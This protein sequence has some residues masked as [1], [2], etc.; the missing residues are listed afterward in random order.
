MRKGFY[1]LLFILIAGFLLYFFSSMILTEVS[2][3][4]ISYL[5]ANIKI[6]NFEYTRP[7]FKDVRISAFNTVTWYG[8][9]T[10][11][12]MVRNEIKNT[13]EC[14]SVRIKEFTIALES[15][16]ERTF[17]ISAKGLSAIVS[18]KKWGVSNVGTE[19]PDRIEA[20][21]IKVKVKFDSLR[22]SVVLAEIRDMSEEL[23]KFSQTGVT[24]IPVQFAAEEI[25]SM[26]KKF[27][28]LKVRIEQEGDEY[29]LIVDEKSLKKIAVSMQG[30]P[31]T[32]GD[33]R[34]LSRNPLRAPQLMRI[35]NKAMSAVGVLLAQFPVFPQDAGHHVLWSYLLAKAYGEEFAKECGDAHE[36]QM[37][38]EEKRLRGD[39][40]PDV[41]SYQD[42]NNN[43]VGRSYAALGYEESSVLQRVLTDSAVIRDGEVSARYNPGKLQQYRNEMAPYLQREQGK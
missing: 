28:T 21:N 38:E 19:A 25:F 18:T 3:L 31:L 42:F 43:A 37:D 16:A 23:R 41:F 26:D 5:T 6:P 17:L 30:F 24:K 22:R 8:V 2:E 1:L 10:N 15:L 29:R 32:T 11:I 9:L 27:Y 4:T 40:E 14:V 34:L 39:K 35:R 20:G 13:V 7:L 12:T 33:I 36:A